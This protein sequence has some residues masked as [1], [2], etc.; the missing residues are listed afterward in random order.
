MGRNEKVK[1]YRVKQTLGE[2]VE[3]MTCDRVMIVMIVERRDD[4]E[5]RRM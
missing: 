5:I 1:Q 2:E 4:R 3:E